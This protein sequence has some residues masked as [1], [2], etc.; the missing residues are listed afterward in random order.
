MKYRDLNIQTQRETPN[1]ARTEGFAFLVRAGYLTRENVPTQ[2]GEY[3]INHLRN[4]SK[5]ESFLSKL[6]IPT[7]NSDNETFFPMPSGLIEVAHCPS[8]KY[9][10][11][12]ELAQFR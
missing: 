12:L 2:L 8:C 1:N 9:T 7:I 11:R 5:D 3:S 4:S 6:S 10:E